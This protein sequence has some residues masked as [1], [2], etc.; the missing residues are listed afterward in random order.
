MTVREM[1]TVWGFDIDEKPLKKAEEK[2]AALKEG[3]T[4]L[5]TTAALAAASLFGI[6][7]ITGEAAEE[8]SEYA[9][10]LDMNVEEYQSY[11]RAAQMAGVE[12]S[13]FN[14]SMVLMKNN[15]AE[16]ANGNEKAAETFARIGV[17]W[18][19][20]NGNIKSGGKL[21]MEVADG[22]KNVADKGQ[23]MAYATQL[24][25]ARNAKMLAFL[26]NGSKGLREFMKEGSQYD[27]IMGEEAV[28]AGEKF[29]DQVD[30]TK[31][32]LYGLRNMLGLE[33]MPVFQEVLEQFLKWVREN[34]ELIRQN[35][36]GFVQGLAVVTKVLWKIMVPLAKTFAWFVEVL[37]G[38]KGATIAF[39][40]A[41]SIWKGMG[42]LTNVAGIVK[43]LL[44]IPQ[45]LKA[46]SFLFIE[47]PWG[48]FLLPLFLVLQDIVYFAM[49]KKSV[50]G[51]MVRSIQ[52]I[53]SA[54]SDWLNEVYAGIDKIVS[55]IP[56]L[57]EFIK[58]WRGDKDN[59]RSVKDQ[60]TMGNKRAEAI[61]SWID[62]KNAVLHGRATAQV[63]APAGG[64]NIHQ[65]NNINI[66]ITGGADP[67][68]VTTLK[69]TLTDTMGQI[70][71][72]TMRAHKRQVER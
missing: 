1:V 25:G 14:Q 69:K 62:E 20:G 32:V 22:L 65:V 33:L 41:W 46:L 17:K 57:K 50:F 15:A 49:G 12:Q 26:K 11:Q 37:G 52:D 45:V 18:R 36:K 61:A 67:H 28:K 24:F 38:A 29:D 64:Y 30:K 44:Q 70:N 34:R 7:A 47:T 51:V 72:E 23:R 42:I 63:V 16:A 43:Y 9:D 60:V 68:T 31:F 71:R 5:G 21:L 3:F 2:L 35:V 40:G 48:M 66:P 39:I 10:I 59:P 58:F 56:L 27:F 8:A 4:S 54:T 6:S 53:M 19:D 13:R 55:E